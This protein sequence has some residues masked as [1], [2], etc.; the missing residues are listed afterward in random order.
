MPFRFF[1]PTKVY[2]GIG[3]IQDNKEEF[4]QWGKKALVV[5]GRNSARRSGALADLSDSLEQ[6][7]IDYELFDKI[8]ENPTIEAVEAAG[9]AARRFKPDMIIAIGGGSPLDAAKAIAV[10]AAND[11]PARNLYDGGFAVPPLPILAVPLTAGTGSEVTPY[12]ILTDIERQTKRSFS[13]PGLFPKAAFLDA[14][15]TQTLSRSVTVNSAV[16]ALSH[17]IEGYLSRRSTPVTDCM[18]LEAIRGFGAV[19]QALLDGKIELA[20]RAAL[21]QMS[22]VAGIVL[23]QTATTLV[24]ALGYSLTYFSGIPHGRANGL[25][26]AEYLRFNEPVIPEKICAVLAALG[27]GSID[28]FGELL[29]RLLAGNEVFSAEDFE[30]FAELASKAPNTAFTA[31]QPNL[32]ELQQILMASLPTASHTQ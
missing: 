10:L 9:L 13:N 2:F 15:Y 8:E 16:D 17:A 30:K 4:L 18:A 29:N 6:A 3:C 1:M 11:M 22:L 24:H 32:A 7:K 21:L 31:R 20:D 26:L 23:A 5:T 14:R 12:S 25:L 27:L 19:K 28:E